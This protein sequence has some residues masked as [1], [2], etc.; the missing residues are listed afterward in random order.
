MKLL[1]MGAKFSLESS[2]V[3]ADSSPRCTE[4]PSVPE[5]ILSISFSVAKNS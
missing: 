4:V 3:M 5:G 2:T 1:R